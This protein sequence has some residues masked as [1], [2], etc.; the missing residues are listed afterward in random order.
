[1][2]NVEMTRRQL[3]LMA[4]GAARVSGAPDKP[5]CGDTARQCAWVEAHEY[6]DRAEADRIVAEVAAEARNIERL[7]DADVLV[8][9]FESLRDACR[10]RQLAEIAAM[11]AG[12]WPRKV[13]Y[14][15]VWADRDSLTGKRYMV[16]FVGLRWFGDTFA[17][18]H[19]PDDSY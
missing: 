10:D 8:L 1:M 14:K 17:P 7:S 13:G 19:T 16:S 4:L 11:G 15:T 12:F 6:H 5:T 9:D 2:L 18:E 3:R